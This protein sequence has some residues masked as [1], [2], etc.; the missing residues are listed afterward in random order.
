MWVLVDKNSIRKKNNPVKYKNYI[1]IRNTINLVLDHNLI[2]RMAKFSSRRFS[3][4]I[5]YSEICNI[6]S[7]TMM[8]VIHHT[9]IDNNF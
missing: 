8:K 4:L 2:T 1:T 7:G 3:A 9:T 6:I 5:L